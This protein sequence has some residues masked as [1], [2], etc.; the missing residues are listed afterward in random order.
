[1][2]KIIIE[3]CATVEFQDGGQAIIAEFDGSGTIFLR[4]QSWDDDAKRERLR[5]LLGVPET[6]GRS[7]ATKSNK[8]IRITIEII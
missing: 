7:L 8:T 5:A 1:M 4:L 3:H 2:P 6:L